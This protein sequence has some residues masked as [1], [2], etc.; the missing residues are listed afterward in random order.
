MN[1]KKDPPTPGGTTRPPR[2]RPVRLT[3]RHVDVLRLIGQGETTEQIARSLGMTMPGVAERV[4]R[5]RFNLG[6]I[7]RIHAFAL[8]WNTGESIR[9]TPSGEA[10]ALTDRQNLLLRIRAAGGTRQDIERLL[11]I[12]TDAAKALET[13]VL[14]TTSAVNPAMAVRIALEHGLI[15]G[16]DTLQNLAEAVPSPAAE[17][18]AHDQGTVASPR[19][20]RT[21]IPGDAPTGHLANQLRTANGLVVHLDALADIPPMVPLAEILKGTAA[22]HRPAHVVTRIVHQ[23]LARGI[24]CALVIPPTSA[25]PAKAAETVGLGSAWSAA[26]HQTPTDGTTAYAQAALD[27]GLQPETCTV[28]CT[29]EQSGP[30]LCAGPQKL[31]I[32]NADSA[33]TRTDDPQLTWRERQVAEQCALGLTDEQIGERLKISQFIVSND[34]AAMR[35]KFGVHDRVQVVARAIR[36]ELVD[37]IALKGTLPTRACCLTDRETGQVGTRTPVRRP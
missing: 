3:E 23:A 31:L 15:S 17:D 26:R 25:D 19:P 30:A 7:N 12:S 13:L 32:T 16:T 5:F 8:A 27:L 29:A 37:I 35:R 4:K 2:K 14:R 18:P 20:P 11:G 36:S 1:A 28:I 10:P 24:P 9:T 34:L 22:V 21:G 33:L 6:A